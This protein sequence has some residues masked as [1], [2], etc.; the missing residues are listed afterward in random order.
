VEFVVVTSPQYRLMDDCEKDLCLAVE[1][2]L[3][4]A[5]MHELCDKHNK[6]RAQ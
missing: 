3:W 2:M 1:Q 4:N 6:E 5:E